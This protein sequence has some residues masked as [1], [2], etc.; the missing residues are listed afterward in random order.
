VWQ[1]RDLFR[2]AS[3]R[4]RASF[5]RG[6]AKKERCFIQPSS[7]L[8]WRRCPEGA[9]EVPLST[10]SALSKLAAYTAMGA[11]IGVDAGASRGFNGPD[12]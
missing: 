12:K 8:L 11:K 2:P 1:Q 3:K 5:P 6:E 7:L 4:L 9:E 10:R